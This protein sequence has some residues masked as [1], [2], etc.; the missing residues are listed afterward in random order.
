VWADGSEGE[1]LRNGDY[2]IPKQGVIYAASN[3]Q[4]ALLVSRLLTRQGDRSLID[5]RTRDGLFGTESAAGLR[6]LNGAISLKK[7][8]PVA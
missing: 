1:Y 2:C 4:S 6:T 7:F 3:I 8:V 5:F